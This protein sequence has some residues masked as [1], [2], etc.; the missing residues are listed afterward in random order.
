M[1]RMNFAP[2]NMLLLLCSRAAGI[3][4]K[5]LA[6]PSVPFALCCLCLS[7]LRVCLNG[8]RQDKKKRHYINPKQLM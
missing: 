1:Q 8:Q 7:V 2:T 5:S 3:R 6:E 4:L